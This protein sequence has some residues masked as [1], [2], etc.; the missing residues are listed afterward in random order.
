M[1]K[2]L[3]EILLE[4]GCDHFKAVFCIINE[5]LFELIK[6]V[7]ILH[8]EEKS[9]YDTLKFDKRKK[10]YLLGRIA[11]KQAV[12]K[13]LLKEQAIDSF[14]IQFGVFHFPVVNYI[15]YQ[16][17]QVS[18]T[19]CGNLGVAL[20]YPEEHPL[21]ID[22]EKIDIDKVEAMKSLI[23]DSEYDLISSCSL[24]IAE[25][26]TLIWTIKEALSKVLK[27]GLTLDFKIIEIESCKKEGEIY[28]S[29]F[30][31]FSQYKAISKKIGIH[32]CSIVLPRKTSCDLSVF[33]NALAESQTIKIMNQ[34]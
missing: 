32:V 29:T 25:G 18:I 22:I 19:H 8:P 1:G 21:G 26:S 31:Y 28:T 20:A 9:Y 33:W 17:I 12:S 5:E 10:S 14:A 15:Q 16:N 4:R 30:K 2:Y 13:L 6:E 23:V 7:T 24:E 34:F 11:A 3:G 27:T